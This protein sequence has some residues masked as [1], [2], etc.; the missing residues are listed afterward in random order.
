MTSAK[1]CVDSY[2]DAFLNHNPVYRGHISVAHPALETNLIVL[3]IIKK[4]KINVSIEMESMDCVYSV[5]TKKNLW[6]FVTIS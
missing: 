5:Y 1:N 4:V 3:F 2:N 6:E